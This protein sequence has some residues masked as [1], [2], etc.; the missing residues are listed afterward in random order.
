MRKVDLRGC[1]GCALKVTISHVIRLSTIS[2]GFAAVG[3]EGGKRRRLLEMKKFMR[4]LP[5][6]G[7][8]DEISQ[9]KPVILA[10]HPERSEGSGD[11]GAEMLRFAQHDITDLDG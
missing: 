10:C 6:P 2:E 8:D 11:R 3:S 9:P 4:V 1:R 7:R 5:H